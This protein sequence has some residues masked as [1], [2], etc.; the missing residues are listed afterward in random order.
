M[1][2][3]QQVKWMN[4]PQGWVKCNTVGAWPRE[5]DKCGIGWI[6]RNHKGEALWLGGRTLP[7]TRSVIEVEAEGLRWV[8]LS[9]TRF[10]YK[11]VIFES[12]SKE[13]IS[14]V[15]GEEIKPPIE[16]IVH[17]IQQLL[18][19]FEEVKLVFS[20]REGNRVADRLAQ[21]ALSFQNHDPRLY[22]IV[23]MWLKPI[24]DAE[25]CN[26]FG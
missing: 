26:I 1:Q 18:Q 3:Q 12:D 14:L 25:H 24:V 10:Q 20:A 6:L 4:P 11:K 19:Q 16:H 17:D 22:S 7:R 23:P 2:P 9:I 8:V 15:K 21:V 5:G 13:L